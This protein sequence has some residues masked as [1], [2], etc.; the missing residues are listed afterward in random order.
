MAASDRN[1]VAESLR[2]P[3]IIVAA[4]WVVVVALLLLF[5]WPDAFMNHSAWPIAP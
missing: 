4:I 5:G 1:P 3:L 2:R